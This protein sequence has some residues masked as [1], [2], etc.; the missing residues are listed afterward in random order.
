[1]RPRAVLDVAVKR[2]AIP[3]LG[4]EPHSFGLQP[5]TL[6]TKKLNI[7]IH[8]KRAISNKNLKLECPNLLTD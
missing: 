6:L 4:I 3:L 5:L 7:P 8:E 1:V 2:M